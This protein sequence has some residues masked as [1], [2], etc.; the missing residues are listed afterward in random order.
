LYLPAHAIFSVLVRWRQVQVKVRV[1]SLRGK[2]EKAKTRRPIVTDRV[3]LVL[4]AVTVSGVALIAIGWIIQGK[5]YVPGLLQQLG[6]SLML[7]VPLALLGFMLEGRLRRA[8]QQLRATAEQLDSLTEVT[9]ERLAAASR[10]QDQMFDEAKRAPNRDTIHALLAH[11]ARIGAIDD[12]GVRVRV[13]ETGLRVRFLARG[14]DIAGAVEDADGTALG[15][16]QWNSA[17]TVDSFTRELAA[18]LRKLGKYPGDRNY[19]PGRIFQRLLETLQLGVRS[20]GG[21]HPRQLGH[22]IE[23][24]NEHWAISAEGLYSLD[25]HYDIAAERI[26][27][28]HVDWQRHMRTLGWVDQA[29]FDEA[30]A[31]ARSLLAKPSG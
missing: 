20:A 19:D 31:L 28:A 27:G 6:S 3:F 30:Y 18:V 29:A 15:Q 12:G 23:V 7:L 9:R 2:Q 25:Q 14:D 1:T 4:G 26:T 21:E 11:A 13:P 24:P 10:Q 22:L 5:A 17:E 16:V 8:E